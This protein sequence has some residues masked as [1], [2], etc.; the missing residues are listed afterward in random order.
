MPLLPIQGMQREKVQ[1]TLKS[2]ISNGKGPLIH[3]LFSVNT[4]NV[5]YDFLKNIFSSLLYKY[6][7]QYIEH[8]KY[9]SVGRL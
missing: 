1:L 8:T 5:F 7:I 2:M 6:S 4:V 9:V 3:R